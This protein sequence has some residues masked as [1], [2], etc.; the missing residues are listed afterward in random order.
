[1]GHI[2]GVE[3]ARSSVCKAGLLLQGGTL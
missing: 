3:L 2:V 1:L